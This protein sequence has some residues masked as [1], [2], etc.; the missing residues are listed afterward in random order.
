MMIA[1]GQCIL[2]LFALTFCVAARP[3]R[4]EPFPN[5]SNCAQRDDD[6]APAIGFHITTSYATA[7][8]RYHD[9][10]MANLGKVGDCNS[11]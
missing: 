9:G 6:L 8:V 5:Y 11:Y 2:A 10:S 1:L 3:P 4:F 7:A